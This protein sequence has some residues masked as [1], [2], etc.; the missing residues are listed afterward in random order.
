MIICFNCQEETKMLLDALVDDGHY[1]D[2]AEAIAGAVANLHVLQREIGD[3]GAI[4]VDANGNADRHGANEKA[5]RD[6][7][8]PSPATAARAHGDGV[9][10]VF[11][12]GDLGDRPD[13]LADAPLDGRATGG[14]IPLD[15]WLFG[16]YNKLFPAKASCRALAR[17]QHDQPS[18]L[19]VDEVAR[20]IADE[21]VLLGKELRERDK[22]T[23]AKRHV[24]LATAFPQTGAKQEKGRDRYADQF[25]AD[26]DRAGRLSGLP[27]SLG[28]LNLVSPGAGRILLTNAGRDFATL[29]NPV[30]DRGECSP[31][32][33]FSDEETEFMIAH[34]EASVPAEAHAYRAILA[35]IADGKRTPDDLDEELLQ[36]VAP[37][38]RSKLSPSF[39]SSQRSGAISRMAELALVRRVKDGVR[40]SYAAT[41]GGTQ[42]A[43]LGRGTASDG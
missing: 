1:R 19:P 32:K 12:L 13:R 5:E 14:A 22:R 41:E 23:G 28:L 10:D 30:L 38:I 8:G 6:T 3:A 40:V 18:G 9:P 20:R 42:F 15:Q 7:G 29:S 24:A 36:S 31:D 26:L 43:A 25:V 21:A 2:Y 11:R 35:A 27:F 33:R 34:I 17:L 39:L 16:Q 4:V 37:E